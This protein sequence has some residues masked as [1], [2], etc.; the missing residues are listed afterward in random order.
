MKELLFLI[1][2]GLLGVTLLFAGYRLARFLIPLWG[3]FVG[4]MLGAAG[5]S[6]ALNNVF[7]GTTMGIV[8]GLAVGLLFAVLSYF[9]YSLAIIL[10]LATLGYWLGT[11]VVHMFGINN[12]FLAGAAGIALGA[13]VGIVALFTNVPKY[14]LIFA[15]SVAG[16][17]TLAGGVMVLFNKIEVQ[18]YSYAQATSAVSSSWL[19]S[20]IV[21]VLAVVGIV[22]Q[23]RSNASYTLEQWGTINSTPT[24]TIDQ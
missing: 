15:S 10:F 18:S 4:F 17:V 12:G 23:V 21:I 19:W 2:S 8:V 6:D 16:A 14:V 24:N 22:F 13:V 5:V 1:L 9:F 11:S 3:F 20:V 7:L